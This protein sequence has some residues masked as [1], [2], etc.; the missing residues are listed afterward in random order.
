MDDLY[1]VLGVDRDS[2]Q[3]E[4][5]RAYRR[6]AKAAHPD[7]G[8][9]R[10]HWDQLQIAY[11]VLGDEARRD[12]YNRTGTTEAPQD[13]LFADAV[14]WI[15]QSMQAILK[16]AAGQQLP[17]SRFDL[18]GQMR[19]QIAIWI[20]EATNTR[21][22]IIAERVA[23][24]DVRDRFENAR[25]MVGILTPM[26]DNLKAQEAKVKDDLAAFDKANELLLDVRYRWDQPVQMQMIGFAMNQMSN[27]TATW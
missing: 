14:R 4:I 27:T 18:V 7:A 25:I 11:E 5:R 16:N 17:A 24:E 12:K 9:D 8:G 13:V 10:A 19:Q 22:K 23:L 26:I 6:H 2:D 20:R 15:T 1:D 3:D 21:H